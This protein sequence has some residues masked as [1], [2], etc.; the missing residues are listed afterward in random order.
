M[1][2][3][4]FIF[5]HDGLSPSLIRVYGFFYDYRFAGLPVPGD[6]D[7]GDSALAQNTVDSISPSDEAVSHYAYPEAKAM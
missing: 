1:K 7:T 2:P 5:I 4:E 3:Q 6:A